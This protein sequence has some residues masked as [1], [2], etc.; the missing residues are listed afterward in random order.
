[1]PEIY[2]EAKVLVKTQSRNLQTFPEKYDLHTLLHMTKFSH[3][4]L[5]SEIFSTFLANVSF[6]YPMK[7]VKFLILG[8]FQ[9]NV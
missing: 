8:G 5:I 3:V 9:E 2:F 1:M 7:T 6:Q 4:Q